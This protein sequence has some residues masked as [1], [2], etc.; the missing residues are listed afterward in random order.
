MTDPTRQRTGHRIAR[1]TVPL[2]VGPV[3]VVLAVLCA[4]TGCDGR[5]APVPPAPPTTAPVVR[6]N[7]MVTVDVTG[8]VDNDRRVEVPAPP[9][10]VTAV[11]VA[12]GDQVK[13]G[14]R[15]VKLSDTSAR[16]A[17][18]LA[19]QDLA[20]AQRARDA[21]LAGADT[22]TRDADRTSITQAKAQ[23]VAAQ[24]ALKQSEA[25]ADLNRRHR[26]ATT[27]LARRDYTDAT[28][29]HRKLQRDLKTAQRQQAERLRTGATNPAA[30]LALTALQSDTRTAAAT[31]T[32]T[33]RQ[34]LTAQQTQDSGTLT[35]QQA[36]TI[37]R[38]ARDTAAKA[39]SDRQ[40]ASA[41]HATPDPVAVAAATR[42]LRTAETRVRARRRA[43][44]ATTVRSPL[45]G[46]VL[47][48]RT[49]AGQAWTLQTAPPAT[50]TTATTSSAALT[51]SPTSAPGIVTVADTHHTTIRAMIT[52]NQLATIRAKAAVGIRLPATGTTRSGTVTAIDPTAV[53]SPT[54][55]P[56]TG[57]TGTPRY[58]ITITPTTPLPASARLDQTADLTITVN[59][60]VNVPTIPTT[61]IR[62]IGTTTRV[63]LVEPTVTRDV[64]IRTGLS[65]GGR[66]E[67]R[68]GLRPGQRVL[69][70]APTPSPAT[71]PP[72]TPTSSPR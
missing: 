65:A 20:V 18:R 62:R 47:A 11:D 43:L 48:V 30:D 36:T 49:A 13:A 34:W 46:R 40:A 7:V 21:A 25:T 56:T 59:R 26:R 10:T 39:L 55:D 68:S 58:G 5:P 53:H 32:T 1:A 44:T 50:P 35:D 17:V 70:P 31:I 29:T 61:A 15:L 67:I 57:A 52:E 27:K 41:E 63:T 37:R 22:A 66:T 4:L 23:H 54:T 3:A 14:Q 51:A 64:D 38:Q 45:T 8:W 60:R 2:A 42:T 69:L 24:T 9:G 16:E 12:V 19:E 71:P 72:A 28:T 33:R 6:G